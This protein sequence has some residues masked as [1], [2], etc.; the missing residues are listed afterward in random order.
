MKILFVI[1]YFYPAHAFGGPVRVA[2]D[3][4]K[5]L[6]K[7]GHEVVVYTSDAKDLENRLEAESAEIEGMKVHYLKNLSMFFVK[8]SKLFI[9]PELPQMVKHS[10]RSFDIIYIHE[11][12]TYQN[13]VVHK[14]ARKYGVPYV[15]QAHGSLPK[16][17]RR[18]RKWVYDIFFG[19]NQLKDAAKVIALSKMEA[20]QY[21]CMGIPKENIVIIPNGID[22]K[23]YTNLPPRGY[24]RKKFGIVEDEKIVLYLGRIHKSKGLDFLVEAFNIISRKIEGVRLVIVGPD[25][26]YAAWLRRLA[27]RLGVEGKISFIGF[28]SERDKLGALVDGDVFSTPYF[29]GFPHTFLEACVAGCPIVTTSNELDWI[30]G[31]VGF[32]TKKSLCAF[33]E[34]IMKLLRDEQVKER[35]RTNCINTVRSFDTSVTTSQ[36]ENQFQL[37]ISEAI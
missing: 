35:F 10:L 26:G 29:S 4:G 15:L 17:S 7:Q 13:I 9:T 33:S 37:I 30:P 36:I 12:S 32:V 27:S 11:Y 6:V 16:T 22:L 31:N 21:M 8:N 25:D 28:V 34:A 19:S 24:F 2:Y 3:V 20:E 1:P 5:E 18:V 23:K 14:F